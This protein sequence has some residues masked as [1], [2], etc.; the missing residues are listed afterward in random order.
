M[1]SLSCFGLFLTSCDVTGLRSEFKFIAEVKFVAVADRFG[2]GDVALVVGIWAVKAAVFAAV[3]V[4]AA[5]F[6][7]L[8]YAWLASV[9]VP[10]TLAV[11]TLIHGCLG[12]LW[13][14]KGTFVGGW[15]SRCFV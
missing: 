6:A 9:A 14:L 1:C 12:C 13:L 10:F 7:A 11:V 4:G 8:L 15:V 5:G 3:K 2:I